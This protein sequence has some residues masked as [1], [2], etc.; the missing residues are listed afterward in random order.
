VL[1]KHFIGTVLAFS[2]FLTTMLFVTN[3]KEEF[4]YI[5]NIGS[6]PPTLDPHRIDD[7]VSFRVGIDL[8]EGLVGYDQG[9]NIV[10]L[11]AERYEISNDGKTYTF[12]LR[13]TAKWSNG[14]PVTAHD[15]V[16]SFQRA[17]SQSTLASYSENLVD[18]VGAEDVK[19][20]LTDSSSLGVKAIDD[21][22][23]EI[24]L[25]NRNKEFIHYLALF[26]AA[27]LH[28]KTVSKYGDAWASKVD[29]IVSN[30][31]YKIVE[32]VTGGHI[33]LKKNEHYWNKDNVKIKNVKFIMISTKTN[34]INNFR[35]G[36]EHVSL[37]GLPPVKDESYYKK[38]FGDQYVSYGTFRQKKLIFN[39]K[40]DKFKNVNIRKALSMTI[41]R[42]FLVNIEKNGIVSYS[43]ILENMH[44]GYFKDVVNEVEDYS[45]VRMDFEKR[46]EEAKKLLIGA[47]YSNKNP[48]KFTL[49][50][51]STAMKSVADYITDSVFEDGFVKAMEK[52]C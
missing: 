13:K 28:V 27:P 24:K 32:W 15:Y 11:G 2:F 41:N 52:Y 5:E 29:T 6:N 8:Y 43:P 20:G 39:L 23:L 16:F 40:S 25:R 36:L 45:W 46:V 26:V 3:A 10:N 22:T 17:L 42:E 21:Y 37:I 14:D 33:K 47:G 18:I 50:F 34:D 51:S 44:N 31:A 19:K 48:L 7:V 4:C 9:V 38:Q 49:Y 1:N 30:G 35:Q 12:Y